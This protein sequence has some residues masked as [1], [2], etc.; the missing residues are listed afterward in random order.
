MKAVE[1][2]TVLFWGGDIFGPH[3]V[4]HNHEIT[5]EVECGMSILQIM[6]V[7]YVFISF[8]CI[9]VGMGDRPKVVSLPVWVNNNNNNNNINKW[10]RYFEIVLN[11]D[12]YI[13]TYQFIEV[14]FFFVSCFFGRRRRRQF[15]CS[16][17]F[18]YTYSCAMHLCCNFNLFKLKT[19][20]HIVQDV[21]VYVKL[22]YLITLLYY[23][24]T[25]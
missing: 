22:L 5:G 7:T 21:V 14:F 10:G 20:T 12:V 9:Y 23:I 17:S 24:L 6:C 15:S 3:T 25:T 18:I 4:P 19:V 13:I 8:N 2:W 16:L 1:P 11:C